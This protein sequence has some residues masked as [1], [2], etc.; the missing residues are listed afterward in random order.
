METFNVGASIYFVDSFDTADHLE[1][2]GSWKKSFF[3]DKNEQ[4]EPEVQLIVVEKFLSED[5]KSKVLD[6]SLENS[7]LN[8]F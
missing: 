1:C 2:M 5:L 4:E 7:K 8:F 3:G 6:W